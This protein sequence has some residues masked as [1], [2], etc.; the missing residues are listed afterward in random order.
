MS[1]MSPPLPQCQRGELWWA[2][3]D[4]RFGHEQGGF[5]PVLIV[6]STSFNT[7]GLDMVFVFPLTTTLRGWRTRVRI[8]PPEG[9]ITQ[10]S[11]IIC[12]QLRAIDLRRVSRRVGGSVAPA[13]LHAVGMILRSILEL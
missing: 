1:G 12:D 11:E 10:A 9:G 6:S 5:R 8:L 3:L 13:T 2:D 7:S 4:P